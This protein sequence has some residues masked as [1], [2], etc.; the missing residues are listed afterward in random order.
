MGKTR[1]TQILLSRDKGKHAEHPKNRLPQINILLLFVWENQLCRHGNCTYHR[2]YRPMPFSKGDPTM[3]PLSK[4]GQPR[5]PHSGITT[6]YTC[7]ASE[8]LGVT[9]HVIDLRQR[10][11]NGKRH[12]PLAL[13]YLR[14]D[15]K[16]SNTASHP[17][18]LQT[19]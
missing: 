5:H 19:P 8:S 9:R 16:S 3:V 11:I 13:T 15:W 6:S 1:H 12:T 18:H 10:Q 4:K 7:S 14:N 2:N 17:G